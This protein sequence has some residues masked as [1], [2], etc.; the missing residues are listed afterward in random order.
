MLI[1]VFGFAE[2]HKMAAVGLGFK[3]TLTRKNND[4]VLNKSETIPETRI[5]MIKSTGIYP[6]IHLPFPNKV[7]YLSKFFVRL[8]PSFDIVKD[9]FLRLM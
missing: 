2:H 9:L 3:L 8:P 6:I 7:S 1:E 5:K 4:A